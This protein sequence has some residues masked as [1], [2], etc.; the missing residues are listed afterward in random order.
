MFTGKHHPPIPRDMLQPLRQFI[1]TPELPMWTHREMSLPEGKK[2]TI[3]NC[4]CQQSGEQLVAVKP[5][6][7]IRAVQ[8]AAVVPGQDRI[9]AKMLV[10]QCGSCKTVYW[11]SS[12]DWTPFLMLRFIVEN[13]ARSQPPVLVPNKRIIS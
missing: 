13:Q 12:N 8:W 2:E 5:F 1:E 4:S 3:V 11:C 10:G 6:V 9:V 7:T